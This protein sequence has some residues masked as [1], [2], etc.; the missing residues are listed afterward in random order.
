MSW[1]LL[2]FDYSSFLAE[3]HRTLKA[4]GRL[5][6]AEVQSRFTANEGEGDAAGGYSEPKGSYKPG[7]KA[8]GGN[9]GLLSF[10]SGVKGLGF[11]LIGSP[12]ARNPMF[13]LLSFKKKGSPLPPTSLAAAS[14]SASVSASANT[15][16]RKLPHDS[17]EVSEKKG[18]GPG[19]GGDKKRQKLEPP[20][21]KHQEGPSD[22]SS[23]ND[24]EGDDDG[25]A[26]ELKG[27]KQ[28][29]ETAGATNGEKKKR[30]RKRRDKKK[31]KDGGNNGGQGMDSS[32]FLAP[33]SSS[34]SSSAAR[35]AAGGAGAATAPSSSSSFAG[36]ALKPCIYKRR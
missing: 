25:P 36:P 23:D 33:S 17:S 24:S 9:S 18:L 13:V 6:I 2:F 30:K 28:A 14:A 20:P 27:A 1:T 12:D 11:E 16:K 7:S 10:I 29:P 5:L 31:N 32:S 35:A 22:E 34:S 15:L 26:D 4:G 19:E 8:S 3:A 21:K